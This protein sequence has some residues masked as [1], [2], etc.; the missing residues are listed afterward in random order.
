MFRPFGFW[1]LAHLVDRVGRFV[2]GFIF[3]FQCLFFGLGFVGFDLVFI[4]DDIDV[5]FAIERG[6][7]GG[8]EPAL[9]KTDDADRDG[10]EADEE[11]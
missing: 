4:D 8:D 6:C 7:G 1:Y 10:Y 11:K 2:F 5:L 3:Q 9:I